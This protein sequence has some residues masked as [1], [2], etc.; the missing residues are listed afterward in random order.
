MQEREKGRIL[1]NNLFED[2]LPSVL[3]WGDYG[4]VPVPPVF[5]VVKIDEELY[6]GTHRLFVCVNAP[7]RTSASLY[8]GHFLNLLMIAGCIGAKSNNTHIFPT[9]PSK[10]SFYRPRRLPTT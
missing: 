7:C 8:N 10:H 9:P 6:Y 1:I 5:L 4:T 2:T 3:R